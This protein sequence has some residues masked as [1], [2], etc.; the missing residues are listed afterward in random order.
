MRLVLCR[1][2]PCSQKTDLLRSPSRG[3][4]VSSRSGPMCKP[5]EFQQGQ[6]QGPAPGLGQLLVS[7]QAERWRDG[8]QPWGEGLGGVGWWEAQHDPAMCAHSQESQPDRGLHQEKHGQQIKGGHSPLYSALGRP[9]LES[10]NQL[11]SPQHRKDMDLLDG[12]QR[13]ATKM[14]RVMEHLCYE[15]RLRELGLFSLEKRMLW[16][17]LLGLKHSL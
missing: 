3:S 11:W 16:G 2:E 1:Q 5:H 8:E 14:I 17:D 12:I 13:G 10:C 6:V 9:H 4:W 15:E 7:I